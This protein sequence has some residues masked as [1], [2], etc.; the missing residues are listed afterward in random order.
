MGDMSI[1]IILNKRYNFSL[2]DVQTACVNKKLAIFCSPNVLVLFSICSFPTQSQTDRRAKM[3]DL[4]LIQYWCTLNAKTQKDIILMLRQLVAAKELKSPV[5]PQ[6]K[7][8]K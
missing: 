6:E 7:A 1:T 4:E 8:L 3:S 2:Y 5:F